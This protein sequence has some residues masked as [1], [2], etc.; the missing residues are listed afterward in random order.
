MRL[1]GE[2]RARRIVA[3]RSGGWCE[4]CDRRVAA[5]WHHRVNRSQGG[6]WCP[7]N[8]LHLCSPCHTWVSHHPVSAMARGWHLDPCENPARARVWLARHGWCHLGTGGDVTP[9]DTRT[10]Y[11]HP[12]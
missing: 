8:G 9:L 4:A 6:R 3:A 10:P 7:A 2:R 12:W 11:A 5:E 1:T